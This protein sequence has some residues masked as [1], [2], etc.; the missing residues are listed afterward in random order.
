MNGHGKILTQ[1]AFLVTLICFMYPGLL[2]KSIW[3]SSPRE[4]RWIDL[5]HNETL[6]LQLGSSPTPFVK[7]NCVEPSINDFP[8]DFM[9][10]D[11]RLNHG[12]V[13][14]H[15]LLAIYLFVALALLCE[16]YFIPSLKEI[17]T[18]LRLDCD[19]G[20]TTLMA[21]GSSA[22]EFFTSFIGIFI[23]E[24]DIGIGSIVGS[25]VFNILFITAV[26][27]LFAGSV[28]RLKPWP[29]IRDCVCYILSIAAL[30]AVSYDQ[31]I[32][33]YEGALLV[34][35]YL[36]YLV[37]MYFNASLV[38][39]IKRLTGTKDGDPD[40]ESNERSND[41][42]E[43]LRIQDHCKDDEEKLSLLE[44][45]VQIIDESDISPF[46]VPQ[47]FISRVLWILTL[48]ISCLF[49]V[50]I[51]TWC[52]NRWEK[53]YLVSFFVS[54]VW[55][56]LLTYALV[57]MVLTIGFTIGISDV[58]M[59]LTFLAAGNSSAD[60]MSSLIV[61]RQGNGDMAVA[62]AVRSNIFDILLCLGLPWL[63]KTTAVNLGGRIL[64]ES[65]S[66]KYSALFLFA[67]VLAV[68]FLLMLSKW[69]LN[70]CTGLAFLI[71]Y[72]AITSVVT[73]LGLNFFGDLNL[74]AC[75]SIQHKGS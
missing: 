70:K 7:L 65:G 10:Q 35:M 37:F 18:K 52:S 34:S 20:G 38:R 45:K 40:V 28:L 22:P 6:K 27:G 25:A 75:K 69:Y 49:Y 67:T 64:I 14:V 12:G 13:V 72:V 54:V 8:G 11:Q 2:Y 29:L 39:Y 56:A 53:W 5:T 15:I 21:A 66:I 23:T 60:A 62:N 19:V 31:V 68:I 26:C 50:T 33:W 42:K 48:P 57:W 63:V 59:G 36:L 41:E 58:I 43:P 30:V 3:G 55:I 47:G 73:V 46:S 1:F 71:L 51:P 32:Y 24:S 9:T 16:G 61:A 74:P 4:T 44:E 17:I